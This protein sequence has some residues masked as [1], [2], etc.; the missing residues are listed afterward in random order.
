MLEVTR[1][2]FAVACFSGLSDIH[3]CSG[4]LQMAIY[5][6]DK[7]TAGSNSPHDWLVSLAMDV[8]ALCDM[9]W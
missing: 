6:L 8:A 4:R 2:V 1:A 3:K 5:P 9:W 7:Q